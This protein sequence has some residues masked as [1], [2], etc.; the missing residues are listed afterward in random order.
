MP[1]NKLHFLALSH[2][3]PFVLP[4]SGQLSLA[5]FTTCSSA[6]TLALLVQC[7]CAGGGPGS[8][9]L[10]HCLPLLAAVWCHRW[11]LHFACTPWS[12]SL[13]LQL[14][15]PALAMAC[16][17]NTVCLVMSPH[18]SLCLGPASLLKLLTEPDVHRLWFLMVLG[19]LQYRCRQPVSA[20]SSTCSA[21]LVAI[22]RL[23]TAFGRAA[24]VMFPRPLHMLWPQLAWSPALYSEKNHHFAR[25]SCETAV[26][27]KRIGSDAGWA[28]SWFVL[29]ASMLSL[30]LNTKLVYIAR[31]V[32]RG[33]RIH[34]LERSIFWFGSAGPW[35]ALLPTFCIIALGASLSVQ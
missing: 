19:A 2:T 1:V 34:R 29:L 4:H 6:E 14:E 20:S 3:P 17:G 15:W 16:I 31:H 21:S 13:C 9:C 22:G 35:C 5:L 32:T 23:M 25:E 7:V 24:A 26:K 30:G 33:G 18:C 11:A 12:H 27:A 28:S 10:G 8:P